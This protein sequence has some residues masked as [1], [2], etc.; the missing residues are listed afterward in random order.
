[1]EHCFGLWR[2]HP[3]DVG[4]PGGRAGQER[5][6]GVKVKN[7]HVKLEAVSGVGRRQLSLCV[8]GSAEVGLEIGQGR[9][10][11]TVGR[12]GEGW[13]AS[14]AVQ[15]E[16]PA[17]KRG[18]RWQGGRRRWA[19]GSGVADGEASR[20]EGLG[21]RVALLRSGLRP[22]DSGTAGGPPV[23]WVSGEVG[24]RATWLTVRGGWEAERERRVGQEH[25]K[26]LAK[27]RCA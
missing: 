11:E 15:D 20:E 21:S 9:D 14:T 23:S 5:G 1:M 19:D 3:V 10:G 12:G 27:G 2:K 7:P 17:K 13:G 18:A 16:E 25:E 4:K 24:P 22:G 26:R 6:W 8:W